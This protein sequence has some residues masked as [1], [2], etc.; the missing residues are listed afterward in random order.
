[1][2]Q[3][4][5]LS[6]VR[7]L[8]HEPSPNAFSDDDWLLLILGGLETLA[9]AL[10]YL[11]KTD[12]ATVELVAGTPDYKLPADLIEIIY[13]THNGVSLEKTSFD[14]QHAAEIDWKNADP[15][16]PL[17]RWFRQGDE[18]WLVPAPSAAAVTAAAS[19]VIRYIATPTEVPE[20][21]P[22]SLPAIDHRLA[23]YWAV[24][25][26]TAGY[27][28]SEVAIRRHELVTGLFML[29]LQLSSSSLWARVADATRETKKAVR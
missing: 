18:L 16:N 19:P 23:C 12:D 11:T 5:M 17:E 9:L 27:P 28:T 24:M 26:Q 25:E 7:L 3:A 22:E 4:E 15:A 6:L 21:G 29:R 14:E 10:R 20:D 8:A 13:V 1:M 2:T